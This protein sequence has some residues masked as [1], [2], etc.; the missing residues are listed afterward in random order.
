MCQRD[1]LELKVE[2]TNPKYLAR[3]LALFQ[4]E[5]LLPNAVRFTVTKRRSL[6]P[7]RADSFK[8]PVRDI[9]PTLFLQKCIYPMIQVSTIYGLAAVRG[10]QAN[11]VVPL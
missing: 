4:V 6:Y 7:G 8:S 1:V 3:T 2:K 9:S 10:C 11:V 5:P